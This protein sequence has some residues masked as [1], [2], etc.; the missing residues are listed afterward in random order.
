MPV[1]FNNTIRLL[2]WTI[3]FMFFKNTFSQKYSFT[4]TYTTCFNVFV[5]FIY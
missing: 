4:A 1:L 2:K 3:C 5:K